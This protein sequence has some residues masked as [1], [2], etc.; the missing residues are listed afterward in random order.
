ME[1]YL[2]VLDLWEA[3]EEDYEVPPLPDNPTMVQIKNHKKRRT[4]KSKA[5][6]IL[7]A[8]V[9]TTIFTRIMPLKTAKEVWDYLK[10]ECVGDERIRDMHVL[11]LIREFELQKMKESE[12]TKE[13]SDRLLGIVNKVRLLGTKFTSSRIVKKILVT[14][15]ERYE[16]L[17]TT[18]ENTQRI[19]PKSPWQSY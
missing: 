5:K 13:Y 16:A 15:P 3:V 7:Y 4:R 10:E 2:E 12:T 6:A 9:S 8:V 11:N 18:L 19:C 14:V 1:T 17:I